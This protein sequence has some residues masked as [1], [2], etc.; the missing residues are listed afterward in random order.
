MSGKKT[1][2]AIAL[3][4]V[5]LLF[6]SCGQAQPTAAPAVENTAFQ[7][8]ATNAPTT[9]AEVQPA[10]TEKPIKIAA[11]AAESGIPYFTTMHCG[12]IAAAEKYNVDL[13]WAGPAE[14]DFN[15]Q[16][17]F[18]DGAIAWQPDALVI[19]PTD[20]QALVTYV[21]EWMGNGLPVVTVDVTLT[22]PVELQGIESDQ[23]S[24]GVVA[25]N[26]MFEATQGE[27][28][29]L[30]IGTDPGSFGANQRV[31][32]FTDTM[33]E[34][35]PDVKLL[36]TCYPGHDVTRAAQC[37]SAAIMGNPDL[38]GVYVATSA[39]AGGA[40]SAVIEAGKQG[41]I[42][43]TSFDADPQQLQDLKAGV[44]LTVVAQD[45]YQMGYHAIE[46]LAQDLRGEIDASAIPQHVT[47]PMAALTQANVD[48]P[49]LLKY[50]Y[51]GD[52]NLCPPAP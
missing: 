14:W 18:I 28:S 48:N 40:S 51:V 15:K 24:G 5:A 52:I 10:S 30:T 44:Y 8:P 9:A 47:M 41:E 17:P 45:P 33:K 3:P 39:P 34:L 27:G 4:F 43:L 20:P 11:V 46:M 22:E 13:N 38:A 49:E 35:K 36:P 16:Q 25:A 23:Y 7:A 21:K 32:G 37:T 19:V 29:Y 1:L 6:V 26:A 12:A 50:H 42:L 2:A 31:S